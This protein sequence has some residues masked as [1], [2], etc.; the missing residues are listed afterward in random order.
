MS[1]YTVLLTAHS[2]CW[3]FRTSRGSSSSNTVISRQWNNCIILCG[4]DFLFKFKSDNSTGSL[5]TELLKYKHNSHKCDRDIRG[6]QQRV[7]TQTITLSHPTC[8]YQLDESCCSSHWHSALG[9]NKKKYKTNI[10]FI[11][12]KC[13]YVKP[14]AAIIST[15]TEL[16][17]HS[18]SHK[19]KIN[20]CFKFIYCLILKPFA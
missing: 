15:F 8:Y 6:S 2:T 3:E 11:T 12:N 1:E 4:I 14:L 16:N 5:N 7:I 10:T 13:Y 9:I 19:N 18:R 17:G 20:S